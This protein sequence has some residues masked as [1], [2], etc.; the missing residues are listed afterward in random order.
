[1]P[2]AFQWSLASRGSN[3]S[4]RP[5]MSLK[6]RKPM[7]AMCSRTCS[8]RK[9]KKLTTCSG[10]PAKRARSTGSCVAMPTGHV[11]RWHLR[12]MMQP[13]VISGVVAN[14]NSSAP[15][16]A[17]ITTSRPVCSLPSVCTL[18]R[19][20]RSFSSSTCCVSARPSSHGMPACRIELNGD[21]PVPPLSPLISTTSACA[22]LT[23]AATVPTP[24]SLT[25]FTLMRALGLAFFRS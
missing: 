24:T 13:I 18:I 25:S 12:I 10:W 5:T 21:A 23:P 16:S 17:A 9:K 1:M 3:R 6:V 15:S 19:L 2:L 8:A 20:R 22:L 4:T 14:P 11:F 7:R